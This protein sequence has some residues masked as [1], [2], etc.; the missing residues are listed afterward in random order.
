V[1]G[2]TLSR[3]A[4]RYDTTMLSIAYWNREQYPTLD[5]DSGDFAPNRIERGWRLSITPGYVF[6][7]IEGELPDAP[8]RR[9]SP[10]P[11]G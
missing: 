9:P 10:S 2:D 11:S 6:E 4:R 7:P 8:Q 5:P 1:A 3:I